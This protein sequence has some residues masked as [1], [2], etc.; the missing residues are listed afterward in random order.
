MCDA[1]DGVSGSHM[2]RAYVGS[3]HARQQNIVAIGAGAH[4]IVSLSQSDVLDTDVCKTA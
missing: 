1:Q 4:S 3:R 2:R